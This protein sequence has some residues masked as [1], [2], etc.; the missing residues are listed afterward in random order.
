M[1]LLLVSTFVDNN[2]IDDDKNTGELLAILITM[3]MRWY[4]TGPIAQWSTSR[5]S[6]EVTGCHH[7]ASARI[8]LPWRPPLSTIFLKKTKH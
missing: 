5:A 3:Q 6:L 4:N 8:P 1:T 7:W 2:K